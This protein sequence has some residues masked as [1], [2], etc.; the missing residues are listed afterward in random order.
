VIA[1]APVLT[2]VGAGGHARVVAEAWR[3]AGG[4]AVT[5][6]A[7]DPP[8][9]ALPGPWS[10]GPP[11]S[12]AWLH[13]AI[14]DNGLRRRLAEA[15]GAARW[16]T[17]VHPSAVRAPDAAIGEGVLLG[18]LSVMQ[19]GATI[20]DHVIV[21]TGAVVEHDAAAADFV[22]IAPRAVLLGGV[23]VGAG[24][25][26]GAG[27]VVLPGRRVGAGVVVG[28]G[29]VVTRDVPDGVVVRGAPAR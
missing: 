22:H 29:A 26:I 25:L 23:S 20:G 16:R 7:P 21:N 13:V 28:A 4:G 10:P 18:A 27:A 24:S 3:A 1:D 6:I 11:P 17:V 9:T 14:G 5:F 12:D 19:P 15:A 2:L 8:E